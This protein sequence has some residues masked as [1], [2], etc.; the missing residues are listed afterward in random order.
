MDETEALVAKFLAHR[1]FTD[2]SYEPDGNVPPDFVVGG[3]IAVEVRRLNQSYDFGAGL[4]GLEE[5]AIPL[6]TKMETLVASLGPQDSGESWY[7]YFDF[8]RPIQEW[9]ILKQNVRSALVAFAEQPKRS[10][11][12]VDLRDGFKLKIF[13]AGSPRATFFRMGGCGDDDSG[14]MVLME[15]A[16]NIQHCVNTKTQ[17]I[18]KV[19]HKYLEWWLALVDHVGHGI[20]DFDIAQFREHVRIAHDWNKIIV[21]SPHDQ[22]RYFEI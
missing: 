20:D 6:W 12:T 14:G 13:R 1:G 5:D 9:K 8:A 18:T 17:K 2:V 19:R 11:T 3:R 7:V 15:M 4:K 21:I 22:T 16:R 10:P